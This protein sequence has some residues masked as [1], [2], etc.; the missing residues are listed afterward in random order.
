MPEYE[1]AQRARTDLSTIGRYTKK[2]WGNAQAERYLSQLEGDL[3]LLATS[4]GLGR[5]AETKRRPGL[6]RFESGSHVVFYE[7]IDNG[8][9][10]VRILHKSMLAKQHGV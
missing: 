4:P 1:L 8:I 3:Q 2:K 10:I 6:R 9:F 5:M 7:L